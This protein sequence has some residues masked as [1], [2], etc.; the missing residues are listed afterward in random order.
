MM[1]I[2]LQGDLY[3]QIADHAGHDIDVIVY[4]GVNA[5]IECVTCGCVL[6]DGDR[7]LLV[8]RHG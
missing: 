8:D 1:S 4:A 6:L 3:E 5:A 7:D 2:N